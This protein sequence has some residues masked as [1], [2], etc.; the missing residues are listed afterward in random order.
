MLVGMTGTV[1]SSR[2]AYLAANLA[3]GS[4]TLGELDAGGLAQWVPG[5]GV[6]PSSNITGLSPSLNR[7][8]S[9]VFN[10]GA[11]PFTI[12]TSATFTLTISA[13][14]IMNNSGSHR[15]LWLLLTA[16]TD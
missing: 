15:A 10:A 11:S 8:N 5:H 3:L 9:M 1:M 4:G 14:G 7:V 16:T 13:V 6:V 2:G 12:T